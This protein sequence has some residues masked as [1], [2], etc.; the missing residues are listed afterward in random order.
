[1]QSSERTGLTVCCNEGVLC[2][3]NSAAILLSPVGKP[4]SLSL[5][6]DDVEILSN[7]FWGLH[8][9]KV[10]HGHPRVPNVIIVGGKYLW[11]DQFEL[12]ESSPSRRSWDAVLFTR[13]I[14]QI[15]KLDEEL[16]MFGNTRLLILFLDSISIIKTLSLLMGI[17][18]YILILRT[19]LW[20]P[21]ISLNWMKKCI[22]NNLF[23]L[24]VRG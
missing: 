7:L 9:K 10:V 1:V 19:R 5:K 12:T 8:R 13:S 24:A 2:F 11:I 22:L 18:H 15:D 14:L 16:D 23:A 3:T 6:T 4:L 17:I 20:S 21:Y